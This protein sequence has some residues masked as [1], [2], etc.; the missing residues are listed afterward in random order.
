MQPYLLH[1]DSLKYL[2]NS[3]VRWQIVHTLEFSQL[4]SLLFRVMMIYIATFEFT[5]LL[6]EAYMGFCSLQGDI[7]MGRFSIPPQGH[8]VLQGSEVHKVNKFG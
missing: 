1:I 6:E 5:A 7:F 4:F 2:V 3:T 8:V